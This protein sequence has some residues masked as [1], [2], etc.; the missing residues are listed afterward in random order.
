MIR[1]TKTGKAFLLVSGALY[2]ASLTS[3][4]G[5]LLLLVGILFGCV[6][7]NLAIAWQTLKRIDVRTPPVAHLHEGERLSQ[8]WRLV[9]QG[10]RAAGFLQ[11][12]SA[13]GVLFRVAALAPKHETTLLPDLTFW[14]R[15]VY[16][17]SGFR[18][19]SNYPFGL[20]NV[21]RPLALAGEVV[22]QPAVYRAPCPRAAGFD[23]VVGGKYKGRRHSTSGSYFAGVRPFQP[24]DPLK[25]IHWKSSS[26]GQ[27]LMVKTFDEELS[28]RVAIIM[29]GGH[30]GDAQ[31]LDDCVRA[32]GSLIFAALDEG[33]HVEWVGLSDLRPLL[34]PPFADGQEILEALARVTPDRDCLTADRLHAAAH[35]ISSR[36]AIC[37][38][39]TGLNEAVREGVGD[40]MRQ[41]RVVTLYLPK[42][43]TAAEVDSDVPTLRYGAHE[44]LP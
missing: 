34:I 17:L 29:D 2:L 39:L 42:K 3:Q 8:P 19:S 41:N 20:V 21:S 36:S 37:L 30:S 11:V 31:V 44:I 5:L 25:H 15:G 14:K 33:H 35:R 32:A 22:V 28:G 16:A 7:V 18:L 43:L 4:S 24:E 6:A 10:A 26:K 40:W 23:A 38:V 9:N 1:L 13:E 27:G 12:E